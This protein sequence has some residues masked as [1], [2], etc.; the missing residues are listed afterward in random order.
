MYINVMICN[1]CWE[2]ANPGRVP[3][4]IK[5]ASEENCHVC[6]KPT[7]SGI[8]KRVE[9]N[10][11]EGMP[12]SIMEALQSASPLGGS[13]AASALVERILGKDVKTI[14]EDVIA[15]FDESIQPIARSVVRVTEASAAFGDSVKAVSV[16]VPKKEYSRA[17]LEPL[18]VVAI[19]TMIERLLS[20]KAS[21]T[22]PPTLAD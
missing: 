12:A 19:D 1:D 5:G 22:T 2:S 20:I 9:S 10:E 21:I 7:T 14:T 16:M 3:A 15:G 6:G 18:M 8:M 11:P 17:M 13:A 4:A